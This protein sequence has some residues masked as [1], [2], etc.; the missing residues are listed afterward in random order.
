MKLVENSKLRLQT[1][2][3]DGWNSLFEEVAKFYAKNN[4]IVLNMDEFYQPRSRRK[5]Q[6]IKN[7]HHYR[8]ELY[9][10]I[11]DIQL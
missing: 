6:S 5:A 1:M 7:L 4:I 11:M 9:Y 2:R 3:E 8:V 10:T